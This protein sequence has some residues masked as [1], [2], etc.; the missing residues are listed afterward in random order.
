MT[1]AAI[2]PAQWA[3]AERTS[4]DLARDWAESQSAGRIATLLDDACATDADRAIDRAH[5]LL[6]DETWVAGMLRPL[7]AA[8]AEEPLVVL[9]LGA[10]RHAGRTTLELHRSLAARV[11]VTVWDAPADRASTPGNRIVMSGRIGVARYCRAG[12]LILHRWRADPVPHS[13]DGIAALHAARAETITVR[14][15]DIIVS[16]GRCEGTVVVSRRDLVVTLAVQLQAGA[17][18]VMR[19][20][21]AR[22]RLLRAASTDPR[23]SRMLPLLT[24][25]RLQGRTDAAAHFAAASMHAAPWLR[26]AAMRE[27]LALDAAAARSRLAEMAKDDPASEVRAAAA[28]TLAQVPAPS[29]LAA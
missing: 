9:P 8:L 13:L 25:L 1:T 3:E 29:G 5:R 22:G 7:M 2:S 21:S 19:E 18:P 20:F 17:A 11:V 4:R 10:R 14:D 27:W 26:W 12:G 15:G 23:A 16:D 6:T 28:L 24:L